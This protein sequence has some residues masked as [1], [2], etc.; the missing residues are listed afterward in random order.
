MYHH[1]LVI[2]NNNVWFTNK[3]HTII[4]AINNVIFLSNSGGGELMLS[5]IS[6]HSVTV[7]HLTWKKLVVIYLYFKIGSNTL[8]VCF[9]VI[10][11]VSY[12]NLIFLCSLIVK[13][14]GAR[15]L[16][17]HVLAVFSI[18][19]YSWRIISVDHRNLLT[20]WHIYWVDITECNLWWYH[21]NFAW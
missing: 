5:N 17:W 4:E 15:W 10:S 8:T 3:V 20:C 18:F 11:H 16:I 21:Y 9:N 14:Y 13:F 12:F 6:L 19:G 2:D 7:A 1:L